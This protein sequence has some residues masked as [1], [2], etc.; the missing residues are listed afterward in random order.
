MKSRKI[1]ILIILVTIVLNFSTV[2]QAVNIGEKIG[3]FGKLGDVNGNK[4]IDD[5]RFH[6]NL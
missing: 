1:G 3:V 2:V 4:E 6:D 5:R